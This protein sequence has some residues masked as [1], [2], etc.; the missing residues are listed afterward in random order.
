[1]SRAHFTATAQHPTFKNLSRWTKDSVSQCINLVLFKVAASEPWTALLPL[2]AGRTAPEGGRIS[3]QQVFQLGWY[4]HD[5]LLPPKIRLHEVFLFRDI[6]HGWYL[7]PSGW[8]CNQEIHFWSYSSLH[9]SNT[10]PPWGNDRALSLP[11]PEKS[12]KAQRHL[13]RILREHFSCKHCN[14]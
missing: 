14:F 7:H 3:K 5:H 10:F 4:Q 13:P 12:Q 11:T 8:R 2:P 6:L 9:S 1:M